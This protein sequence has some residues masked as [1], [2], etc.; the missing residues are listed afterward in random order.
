MRFERMTHSLEG[1]CSIQLSYGTMSF[2]AAKVRKKHDLARTS[3]HIR[4]K[5]ERIHP[6]YSGAVLFKEQYLFSAH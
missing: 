1:C 6:L 5:T 3:P 2:A 4:Q